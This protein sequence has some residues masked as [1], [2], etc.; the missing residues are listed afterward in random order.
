MTA[1]R[2]SSVLLDTNVVSEMA[3]PAP[4]PGVRAFLEAV[5]RETCLPVVVLH[6]LD[7]GIRRLP[8][9]GRRD[10]LT[11]FVRETEAYFQDRILD[12][13]ARRAREAARIRVEA[14]RAGRTL[15][16]ADALI[17]GT[18][19][20]EEIP[21]ATRNVR[22]FAGFGIELIDPWMASGPM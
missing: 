14:E 19:R 1:S 3:R 12:L 11:R 13:T 8:P 15:P 2:S 7:Y 4:D 21:L 16:L 10:R 20:A 17:A 9:G 22:H 5:S 18:A 6:E